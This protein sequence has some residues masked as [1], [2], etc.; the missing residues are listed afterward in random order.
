MEDPKDFDYI[1]YAILYGFIIYKCDAFY[2][3]SGNRADGTL[4]FS[5]FFP[6]MHCPYVSFLNP[7]HIYFILEIYVV[8]VDIDDVPVGHHHVPFQNE[9]EQSYIESIQQLTYSI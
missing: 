6:C 1:G 5:L 7:C 4:H 8:S 2:I 9:N 3:Y